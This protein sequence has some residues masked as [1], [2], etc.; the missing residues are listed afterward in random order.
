MTNRIRHCAEILLLLLSTGCACSTGIAVTGGG[1]EDPTL[2]GTQSET[3][4]TSSYLQNTILVVAYNDDTD[5]GKIQYTST[6]RIVFPGASLLGWSYSNDKGK[7][8]TYGGKVK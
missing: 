2:A 5:D 3:G 6:D 4:A 1:K 8:W 7:T